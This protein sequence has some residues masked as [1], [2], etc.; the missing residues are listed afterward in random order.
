MFLF[1]SNLTFLSLLSVAI[2]NKYK[3]T[4][5]NSYAIVKRKHLIF[6]CLLMLYLTCD[7]LFAGKY[8]WIYPNLYIKENYKHSSDF[9]T[10]IFSNKE[11]IIDMMTHIFFG[12]FQII[13]NIVYYMFV[14]LT[15]FGI[16]LIFFETKLFK[17][18]NILPA[19]YI[20][21]MNFIIDIIIH[22]YILLILQNAIKSHSSYLIVLWIILFI[23]IICH[24][25][26]F[27]LM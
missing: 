12:I 3:S 17:Q 16:Y 9:Y 4:D 22:Y 6:T 25:I 14:S 26:Y 5:N 1:L 13:V 23:T 21:N 15:L 2:I 20:D 24:D 19:H 11:N 10:M 7:L 8:E 18:K 27:I